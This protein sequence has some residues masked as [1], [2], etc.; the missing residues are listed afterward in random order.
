M[1]HLQGDDSHKPDN[2]EFFMP[3]QLDFFSPRP[4]IITSYSIYVESKYPGELK[5]PI[6]LKNTWTKS[7]IV[8]VKLKHSKKQNYVDG[9]F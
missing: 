3:S 9:S 1:K 8:N 2:E 6:P 5:I 7:S 4:Q